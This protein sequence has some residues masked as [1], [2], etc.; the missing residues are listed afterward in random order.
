[1]RLQENEL[2][3]VYL[4]AEE[5]AVAAHHKQCEK[6]SADRGGWSFEE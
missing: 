3:D 2:K 4:E 1:M 6:E 5:K